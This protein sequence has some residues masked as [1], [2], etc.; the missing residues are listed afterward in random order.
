[1]FFIFNNF[2]FN[3][4][5]AFFRTIKYHLT[6]F[7]PLTTRGSPSGNTGD[8]RKMVLGICFIVYDFQFFSITLH[9][10]RYLYKS[11]VRQGH[12]DLFPGS[13]EAISARFGQFW[14]I[15]ADFGN[16]G[17]LDNSMNIYFIFIV[18]YVLRSI[19]R[20]LSIDITYSRFIYEISS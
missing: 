17:F 2:N 18:K 10:S 9:L 15:S 8:Y 3:R 11:K 6:L 14:Q 20:Q 5:D 4:N 12:S 16:I 19:D 13:Q 1:M 7:N